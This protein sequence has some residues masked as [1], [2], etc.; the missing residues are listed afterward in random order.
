[1]LL[2]LKITGIILG[3]VLGIFIAAVCLVL[4]VPVRYRGEAFV[5]DKEEGGGKEF[6]AAFFLSWFLRLV[7]VYVSAEKAFRVRI[8]VLFFTL[9]DTARE[10]KPKKEKKEKRKKKKSAESGVDNK[11]EQ[12]KTA[13]PEVSAEVSEMKESVGQTE[14]EE[15]PD[16]QAERKEEPD[17]EKERP[18]KK[19]KKE[20]KKIKSIISNIIQTSRNFC[21]K[22]KRIK[23]NAETVKEKITKLKAKAER[24]K[25][26]WEAA[27]VVR[28]R[29]LTLKEF[30]YLLKH[31][32]P[33][34]LEGYLRFGFDD[35][36]V[37]GYAMAAYGILYPIWSPKLSVEPDF[38]KELLDCRV[39]I[40]GKVRVWHLLKAALVLFFSKDVRRAVKNIR[41]ELKR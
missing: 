22:L 3:A 6:G 39:I 36:S 35:P 2:I 13:V 5:S 18:R 26:L 31:T 32:K 40:K 14:S 12:I 19:R 27:H 29:E 7:R 17:F 21:G 11:A 24:L 33:R 16:K 4:F 41:R 38:E 8:K 9:Y 30:L 20:K 37:T 15:Q 28:A 25:E 23:E 34:K 10:D 1:M